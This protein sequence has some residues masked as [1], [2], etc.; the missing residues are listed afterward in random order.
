MSGQPK[1]PFWAMVWL[2][3]LGLVGLAAWRAGMFDQSGIGRPGGRPQEPVVGVGPAV[4]GGSGGSEGLEGLTE[5]PDVTVPTTVK[6]YT[7]KPAERLP[8]V[9][10]VS[11]YKPLEND[12]VKFAQTF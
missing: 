2:V 11:G 8:P 9:R 10:G 4:G 3:I 5:A 7:F 1:A 6:E 12:T